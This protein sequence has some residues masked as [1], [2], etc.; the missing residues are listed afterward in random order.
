MIR[1]VYHKLTGRNTPKKFLEFEAVRGLSDVK[2]ARVKIKD[3]ELSIAIING[4]G[5]VPKIIEKIS[6]K[7]ACYDII[8]VMACDGGCI[9]GGGGPKV[10]R[11][12]N[13]NKTKR[14][15]SM[16]RLDRNS[17]LRNSYE[18]KKIKKLYKELLIE[19]NSDIAHKLL[20]IGEDN[21]E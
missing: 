14:S 1:Y 18:N 17:R 4:T 2:E 20:H 21:N 6:Q 12:T 19:P 13:I 3:R 15:L 7:E 5:D 9:A 11:I 10:N 8:E 16:Y